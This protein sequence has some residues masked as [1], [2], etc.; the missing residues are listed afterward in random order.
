M[1][2]KEC[3]TCTDRLNYISL[4]EKYDQLESRHEVLLQD[5]LTYEEQIVE[6]E[7]KLKETEKELNKRKEMFIALQEQCAKDIKEKEIEIHILK[8]NVKD[9]KQTHERLLDDLVKI[10]NKVDKDKIVFSKQQLEK[11]ITN[12]IQGISNINSNVW[13]IALK[14]EDVLLDVLE[15]EIKS[16]IYEQIKQL[17]LNKS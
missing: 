9:W 13:E 12:I 10:T 3:S 15:Q 6:L 17:T 4:C 7:R 14:N 11:A 2:C 8:C 5:N 16:Q 1:K